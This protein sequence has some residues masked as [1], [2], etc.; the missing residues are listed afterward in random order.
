MTNKMS[1]THLKLKKATKDG[2]NILSITSSFE[3][4]KYMKNRS[5][6]IIAFFTA[7]DPSIGC[8][9]CLQQELIFKEAALP[10]LT[11]HDD[12]IPIYF[13]TIDYTDASDIFHE[14][15]IQLGKI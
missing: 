9:A 14:N 2:S 5:Y 10:Y 15:N 13:I 4:L 7:R 8:H 6:H 12:Q 3:Y 1:K 11:Q